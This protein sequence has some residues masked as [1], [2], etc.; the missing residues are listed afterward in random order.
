VHKQCIRCKCNEKFLCID[1]GNVIKRLVSGVNQAAIF[2]Y[3]NIYHRLTVTDFIY[4]VP[5]IH[6]S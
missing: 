6:E 2:M 4:F 5:R 3:K 1:V